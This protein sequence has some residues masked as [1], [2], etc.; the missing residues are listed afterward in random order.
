MLQPQRQELFV[1]G[2]RFIQILWGGGAIII[3]ARYRRDLFLS[4][5]IFFC[6]LGDRWVLKRSLPGV[7]ECNT[8]KCDS[9]RERHSWGQRLAASAAPLSTAVSGSQ[10]KKDSVKY[11]EKT[12]THT[13]KLTKDFFYSP[14]SPVTFSGAISWHSLNSGTSLPS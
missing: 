2:V 4:R 14:S 12:H 13:H 10:I 9:S 6:A 7:T 8:P 5:L 3:S 1:S 11:K